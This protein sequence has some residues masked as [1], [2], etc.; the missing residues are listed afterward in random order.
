MGASPDRSAEPTAFARHARSASHTALLDPSAT[1]FPETAPCVGV[2]VHGTCTYLCVC[3][4]SVSWLHGGPTAR[5]STH[6]S[7]H[8]GGVQR[9]RHPRCAWPPH[10]GAPASRRRQ[11]PCR[12]RRQSGDGRGCVHVL[13]QLCAQAG[14]RSVVMGVQRHRGPVLRSG[15]QG[16]GGHDVP[17]GAHVKK[18]QPEG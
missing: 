8:H 12:L 5:W 15:V 17:P 18:Q 7:A 13:G 3:G 2:Q 9:I 16:G 6:P 4:P 1:H 14:H 10:A 11:C